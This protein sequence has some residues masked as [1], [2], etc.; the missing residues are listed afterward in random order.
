MERFCRCVQILTRVFRNGS[1]RGVQ[2]KKGN[3]KKKED[4]V[5]AVCQLEASMSQTC[6]LTP[7]GAGGKLSHD[8]KAIQHQGI[9]IAKCAGIEPSTITMDLE[10]TDG[11]ERGEVDCGWK[12]LTLNLNVA[13]LEFEDF[14]LL[15]ALVAG[16][17]L[18]L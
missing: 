7:E 10:G 16:M 13:C 6:N 12:D 9:W 2:Y 4:L 8:M 17:F 5:R 3:E 18:L 14:V 15:V 11:R 1:S